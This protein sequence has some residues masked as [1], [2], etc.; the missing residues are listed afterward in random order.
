MGV[1]MHLFPQVCVSE[2]TEDS[3]TCMNI[4]FAEAYVALRFE[5]RVPQISFYNPTVKA[6]ATMI[7]YIIRLE[8]RKTQDTEEDNNYI[9]SPEKHVFKVVVYLEKR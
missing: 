8:N 4:Y 1:I 5:V 2:D 7:W 9:K 3:V 6:C